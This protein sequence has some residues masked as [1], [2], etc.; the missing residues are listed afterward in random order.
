M[1]KKGRGTSSSRNST[2]ERASVI[3]IDDSDNEQPS[4]RRDCEVEI[5][6]VRRNKRPRPPEVSIERSRP[7]NPPRFTLIIDDSP[8]RASRTLGES[9][10]EPI[11]VESLPPTPTIVNDNSNREIRSLIG[12]ERRPR[13]FVFSSVIY[14]S[15]QDPV[16][17]FSIFVG[18]SNSNRMQSYQFRH[19]KLNLFAYY[20]EPMLSPYSGTPYYSRTTEQDR[21]MSYEEMLSI[22]ERIGRLFCLIERDCQVK[23]SIEKGH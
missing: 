6:Q 8:R 4:S 7:S 21:Q 5:I 14:S 16:D 19:R 11:N 9:R 13:D 17:P 10:A 1:D 2:S 18:P 23:E 20:S 15:S 3:V 12:F 22:S